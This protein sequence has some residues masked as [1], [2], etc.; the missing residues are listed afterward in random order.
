M[1]WSV[2]VSWDTWNAKASSD[3]TTSPVLTWRGKQVCWRLQEDVGKCLPQPGWRWP[4]RS[5]FQRAWWR[6]SSRWSGRRRASIYAETSRKICVPSLHA[7]HTEPRSLP[8]LRWEWRCLGPR[9]WKVK[10]CLWSVRVSWDT[11]NAKAS[12]DCTNSTVLTWRGKQVCWRLQEDVGKCL[13]IMLLAQVKCCLLPGLPCCPTS[14][15]Q[16][17]LPCVINPITPTNWR[18]WLEDGERHV[19]ALPCTPVCKCYGSECANSIRS[20]AST[21]LDVE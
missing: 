18:Q 10:C 6:A 5:L 15:G 20:A 9:T 17:T 7:Q 11:W 14:R 12:S 8:A 16:I 2:R 1:Y 4:S 3:C 21:I 13:P 19:H